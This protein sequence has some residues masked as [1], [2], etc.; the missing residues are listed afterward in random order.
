MDIKDID[1]AKV[2][3]PVWHFGIYILGVTA[4]LF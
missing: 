2:K 4:K 1:C 3:K